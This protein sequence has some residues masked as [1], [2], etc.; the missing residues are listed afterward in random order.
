MKTK[1]CNKKLNKTLT[2]LCAAGILLGL[3]TG[4][5]LAVEISDEDNKTL[6]AHKKKQAAKALPAH[7]Q[8]APVH[9]A[10]QPNKPP[11]VS[12][13]GIDSLSMVNSDQLP[14]LDKK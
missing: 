10:V 14:L 3:T 8:P 7:Q 9:P 2:A 6:Q 5:V 1:P 11:E 4:S 13:A 12:A